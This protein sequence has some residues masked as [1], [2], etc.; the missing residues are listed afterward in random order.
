MWVMGFVIFWFC[1]IDW[2]Y[3]KRGGEKNFISRC[4]MLVQ[5]ARSTAFFVALVAFV[6]FV[7]SH[8]RAYVRLCITTIHITI[9]TTIYIHT[10][11]HIQTWFLDVHEY[12]YIYIYVYIYRCVC[13]YI[14]MKISWFP[15]MNGWVDEWMDGWMDGW[16]DE[17][18]NERPRGVWRGKYIKGLWWFKSISTTTMAAW[19]WQHDDGSTTIAA[20]STAR[21]PKATKG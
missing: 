7:A 3:W 10:Y 13:I 20:Q 1:M 8:H 16:M 11:V 14:R 12:L 17:R 19:W 6:A 15:W 4:V 9:H 18:T 21:L 5:V 2:R